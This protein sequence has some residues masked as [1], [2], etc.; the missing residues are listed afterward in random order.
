MNSAFESGD[1]FIEI[2]KSEHDHGGQGW[3]FGTCL[4]SPSKNRNGNDSYKLMRKPKKGDLVLHFY[5]NNWP[6]GKS[7]SRLYGSSVVARPFTEVK[8]EPPTPGDWGGRESYYRIELMNFE[9]F[10]SPIS[11]KKIIEYYGSDIRKEI[12]E[13]KPKFYPFTTHGDAIRTTQG[14]YLAQCTSNLYL[15]LKDALEIENEAK[16]ENQ[17]GDKDIDIHQEYSEQLRSA[18]ESYFFIRNK[19]LAKKAKELYGYKCCICNFS[20]EETYGELG[21]EFIECYHIKPLSER[22]ESEWTEDLKT[23]LEDVIVVCSNCHRMIHSKRPALSIEIV[24]Q[25]LKNRY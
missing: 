13:Y 8:E 25:A 2:T 22:P 5:K 23:S 17:K 16:L 1:I 20:F 7:E 9:Q 12:I 4:W 14:M 10:R 18:K 15:I 6:D 3:N 21:K 24:K 11:L 19:T